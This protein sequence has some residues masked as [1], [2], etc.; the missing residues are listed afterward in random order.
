MKQKTIQNI[1]LEFEPEAKNILPALKKT[2]A[3]FGYVSEKDA[4]IM[5]E[6]FGVS[7]SKIFETASFYDEIKTEKPA[8]ITIQI[9]SSANC[10]VNGSFP[11]IR[12]IEN[13]LKIKVEEISCLGRCSDGPVMIING[14]IYERVTESSVHDILKEYL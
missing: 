7:E 14:K 8:R 11:I 4:R 2:S 13:T 9:C 5:A 6:Y 12:E 10:M 1:I 3:V